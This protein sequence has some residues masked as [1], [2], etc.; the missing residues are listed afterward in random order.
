MMSN[1]TL[2]FANFVPSPSRAAVNGGEVLLPNANDQ[3]QVRVTYFA[4]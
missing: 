2:T 3:Q 1:C 4:N